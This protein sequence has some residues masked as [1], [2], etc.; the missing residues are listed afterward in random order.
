MS[1][2]EQTTQPTPIEYR[3]IRSTE[4][5]ARYP[6]FYSPRHPLAGKNGRVLVHRDTLYA[7]VGPGEH[8]CHWCGALV[9]WTTKKLEPGGLVVDH[10]DR[11]ITAGKRVVSEID[12]RGGALADLIF[13]LVFAD[14][15]H[16]DLDS[17]PCSVF[18]RCAHT[19]DG[20]PHLRR[21]RAAHVV[22]RGKRALYRQYVEYVLV[23][24]R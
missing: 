16:G 12:R 14:S 10:L 20:Y 24:Q 9:H 21:R 6:E 8:P 1:L 4:G 22:A 15:L 2:S 13:D 23:D 11:D 7:A 18:Q 17:R 3:T 5:L 19:C